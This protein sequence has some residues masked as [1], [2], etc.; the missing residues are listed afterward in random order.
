MAEAQSPDFGA[1]MAAANA[2][3]TVAYS[4]LLHALTQLV[5]QIVSRD[6]RFV[7]ANEVEDVVQDVLLSVHS[8]R[9]T[10][11]PRRPF[12]PWLLAIIRRR[13]VDAGRRRMRRGREIAL[14]EASV[15][16]PVAGTNTYREEFARVDALRMAIG[17]L[18]QGQREAVQLLKLREMSLREASTVTGSSIGAL[19]V[20][21]HRAIAAL[22]AMLKKHAD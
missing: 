22:R 16:F 2:G 20:A 4:R 8:V 12:M 14:D 5:R 10:Y 9:A 6:H 15:T 1:L 13:V 7:G 3:D 17:S 18:P 11:D 21:T 19:K